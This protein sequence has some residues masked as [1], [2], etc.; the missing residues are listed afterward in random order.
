MKIDQP[1]KSKALPLAGWGLRLDV[2]HHIVRIT[3]W[4]L[5][6]LLNTLFTLITAL[7]PHLPPEL[8]DGPL[9][10]FNLASE[11]NL[12]VWWSSILLFL[13]A[14]QAYSYFSE[15]RSR[16][17]GPW[18]VL[19][20]VLSLL[21]M[22]EIGSLH[23]LANGFGPLL[24]VMAGFFLLLAY[25]HLVLFFHPGTRKA[26][27][28]IGIGFILMSSAILQE[29][30]EHIVRWPE[31]SLGLRVGLEEGSEL[32]GMT[33]ILWGLVTIPGQPDENKHSL[34]ILP[35]L[36]TW[37]FL[38]SIVLGGVVLQ[39]AIGLLIDWF[40]LP[41]TRGNPAVW[42]P[43]VVYFL[44]FL[45]ASWNLVN[46]ED[47]SRLGRVLWA[48]FFLVNSVSA[49]YV[50]GPRSMSSR[51]QR[52]GGFFYIFYGL[53]LLVALLLFLWTMPGKDR[54]WLLLLA[55]NASLILLGWLTGNITFQYIIAGLFA[56]LIALLFL[57]LEFIPNKL[58]QTGEA[59]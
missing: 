2:A 43:E 34:L 49:V 28:L 9:H 22:D 13:L 1:I 5:I 55:I 58:V 12:S 53:Q 18:L 21:S 7:L 45:G 23:E 24:P 44:L 14:V 10:H 4:H 11:M 40:H 38:P 3:W 47:R 42:F 59:V 25:A 6:L 39:M 17:R 20:A 36:H 54:N 32:F 41:M 8:R 35:T 19:A 30:V 37:R 15:K 52:I 51:L 57:R 29:Y 46:I 26:S 48:F 56:G 33:V 16:L 31:W 50:V 27:I